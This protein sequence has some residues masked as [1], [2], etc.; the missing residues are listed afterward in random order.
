M[1][2]E[3]QKKGLLTAAVIYQLPAPNLEPLNPET[4]TFSYLI[5]FQRLVC[6]ILIGLV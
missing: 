4:E 3:K 1:A 5:K 6:Q 2:D